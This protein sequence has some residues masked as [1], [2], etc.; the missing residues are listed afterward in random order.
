M[1]CMCA[2]VLYYA[3][4]TDVRILR[5]CVCYVC[6]YCTLLGLVCVCDIY[7][8]YVMFVC[9]YVMYLSVYVY[10]VNVYVMCVLCSHVRIRRCVMLCYV[11]FF[12]THVRFCNYVFMYVCNVCMS[13]MCMLC[14]CVICACMIC[15][16]IWMYIYVY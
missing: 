11:W 1:Y 7:V 16:Y 12:R 13:K 5:I 10:Y 4:F 8:C 6:R 3:M 9:V 14:M 2:R 15:T